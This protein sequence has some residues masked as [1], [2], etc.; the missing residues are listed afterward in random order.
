MQS[1]GTRSPLILRLGHVKT[2]TGLSRSSIYSFIKA[3]AFPASV[4]LGA[5]AVGWFEHEV[6]A[7]LES[8]P[9]SQVLR[10]SP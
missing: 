7:W 5:R 8:R 6:D 3:G 1:T 10:I 9:S 2:K 4:R